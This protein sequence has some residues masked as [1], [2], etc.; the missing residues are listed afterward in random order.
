MNMEGTSKDVFMESV[1]RSK[2]SVLTQAVS[3]LPSLWTGVQAEHS[4]SQV[5]LGNYGWLHNLSFYQSQKG[6][7]PSVFVSMNCGAL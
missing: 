5:L 1:V 3:L 7:F 6:Y 4:E 2:S